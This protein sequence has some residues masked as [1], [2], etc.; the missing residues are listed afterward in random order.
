MAAQISLQGVG[1]ILKMVLDLILIEIKP[2]YHKKFF[3]TEAKFTP[4]ELFLAEK[5]LSRQLQGT[6]LRVL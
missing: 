6:P 3:V 5:I 2:F 4:A 1:L